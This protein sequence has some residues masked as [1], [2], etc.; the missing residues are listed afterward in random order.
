MQTTGSSHWSVAA[1]TYNAT[2]KSYVE[3]INQYCSCIVDRW[4]QSKIN[5]SQR[6]VQITWK[7]TGKKHIRP[8]WSDVGTFQYGG[9]CILMPRLTMSAGGSSC[10]Y[11]AFHSAP[12]LGCYWLCRDPISMGAT[13]S[14][15]GCK[16]RRSAQYIVHL[17]RR[18][19]SYQRGT[20]TIALFVFVLDTISQPCIL[21]LVC[22]LTEWRYPR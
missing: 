21:G 4:Y 20:N 3:T 6:D 2:N 13:A 7:T 5:S 19:H 18:R 8:H 9:I 22:S 10:T 1:E 15:G 11:S 17:C 14:T 12:L 16:P